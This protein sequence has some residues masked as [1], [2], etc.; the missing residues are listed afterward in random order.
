MLEFYWA[1]LAGVYKQLM[2]ICSEADPGRGRGKCSFRFNALLSRKLLRIFDPKK[3]DKSRVQERILLYYTHIHIR[4]FY[5]TYDGPLFVL[6]DSIL[7]CRLYV[8]DMDN[9]ESH[10]VFSGSQH[11]HGGICFPICVTDQPVIQA[12]EDVKSFDKAPLR[13]PRDSTSSLQ[14]TGNSGGISCELH[15]SEVEL[16]TPEHSKPIFPRWK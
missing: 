16:Q 4:N 6:K 9:S 3:Q 8:L 2:A 10:G 14:Q 5:K 13:S 1:L 7:K 15:L 12:A 11:I